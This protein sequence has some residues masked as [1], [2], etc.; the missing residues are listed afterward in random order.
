MQAQTHTTSLKARRT[1]F[2]AYQLDTEG[3]S[4]S[5]FDGT[6]FTLIEARLTKQSVA[7]VSSEMQLCG[8]SNIHCLH[9]TSWDADH[10]KETDLEIILEHLNPTKIEYP[11]YSPST[12]TGKACLA[13]ISAFQKK[14]TGVKTVQMSPAYIASLDRAEAWGYR[15]IVYHP[16]Y[17]TDNSNDNSTVKLFRTGSFSVAS[18]GD[19]ES[20]GISAYLKRQNT[21]KDEVDVMILAH[22]GADNGFTTNAFLRVVNPTLAVCSS[23]FGNQYDH[24]RQDIR[25]MLFQHDIPIFT[26]KT[27]DVI[28]ESISPHNRD[29]RVTNLKADSQEI[30]SQKTFR[31]KKVSKLDHNYDTVKQLYTQRRPFY[32]RFR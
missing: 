28:I 12:D 26:T 10:C 14:R 31:A 7:S 27:G 30:A 19:V 3:S 21:F 32:S 4:F 2:R 17:I 20:V 15:D 5:Y 16:T 29:Y 6:H 24:P 8:V 11:G 23:N 1:R 13:K 18:L 25:E 9:I 22:H